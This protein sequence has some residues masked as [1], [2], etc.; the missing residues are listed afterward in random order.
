MGGVFGWCGIQEFHTAT[1]SNEIKDAGRS[2]VRCETQIRMRS[3]SSRLNV[4]APPVIELGRPRGSV[5]RHGGGLFERAAVLEIGR[6]AGRPERVV[7][8]FGL[9]VGRRRASADH[10][11]GVGL[12]QRRRRQR[13][14]AAAD[15][16]KQRPLR[17][18]ASPQPSI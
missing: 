7:A 15:G 17:I 10:G 9:D 5:V 8:D 13:I 2:K 18:A 11:V 1:Q 4:V 14:R 16:P 6:D 12:G 3:T